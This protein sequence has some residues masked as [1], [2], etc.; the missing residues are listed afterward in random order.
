M[1]K[2]SIHSKKI[3]IGVTGGLVVLVGLIMVPYPG[4]GWLVVFAGLAILATEFEFARK[5]L[6]YGRHKYD[7][8]TKWL[9]AQHKSIQILVLLLVGLITITTVWLMNGFGILD[10]VLSTNIDWLHSPFIR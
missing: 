9:L 6:E 8:W 5:W 1:K 3:L 4:P 2:I 7:Q 10:N